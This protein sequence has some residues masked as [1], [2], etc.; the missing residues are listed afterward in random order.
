MLRT[1]DAQIASNYNCSFCSREACY[2]V[3]R[4]YVTGSRTTI[5]T[6]VVPSDLIKLALLVSAKSPTKTSIKDTER[7]GFM[8][9]L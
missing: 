2:H 8:G 9:L 5:Q 3:E 1:V 4:M 6:S 7:A